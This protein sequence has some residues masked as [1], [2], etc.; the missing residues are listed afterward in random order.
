[1]SFWDILMPFVGIASG[2]VLGAAWMDD[3]NLKSD[4]PPEAPGIML[5]CKTELDTNPIGNA[6]ES[7]VP[8]WVGC[9]RGDEC[10]AKLRAAGCDGAASNF[11]GGWRIVAGKSIEGETDG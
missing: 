1:M 8:R 9:V 6:I 2:F 3:H 11:E 7:Y 5:L 10:I 4:I